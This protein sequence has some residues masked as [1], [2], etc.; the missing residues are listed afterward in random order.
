LQVGRWQASPPVVVCGI[1]TFV[2]WCGTSAV[3]NVVAVVVR[4]GHV[5]SAK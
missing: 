4:N 5:E 1:C 2:V 3:A